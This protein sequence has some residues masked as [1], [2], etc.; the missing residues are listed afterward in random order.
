M[1]FKKTTA[2]AAVGLLA[3]ALAV[4]VVHAGSKSANP[5]AYVGKTVGNGQCVAFVR[6]AA[7]APD[8]ANWKPGVQVRGNAVPRG[9]G[10]AA[11]WAD[12]AYPDDRS[13]NHAAVYDGQDAA[14]LWVYDQWAGKRPKPVGRRYVPFRAG[15]GSPSNDGDAY[16]VIDSK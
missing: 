14:G 10:I 5:K 16:Y 2:A 12:G 8:A 9:T 3:I 6:Q 1:R 7:G 11:G 4:G 13:G 15:A